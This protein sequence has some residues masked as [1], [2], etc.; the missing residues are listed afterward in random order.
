MNAKI[1]IKKLSHIILV[2]LLIC[3]T[4]SFAQNKE[5]QDSVTLNIAPLKTT[6]NEWQFEVKIQ[7]KLEKSIYLAT[8]PT[9]VYGTKGHY[10]QFEDNADSLLKISSR[11]FPMPSVYYYSNSTRVILKEIKPAEIFSEIILLKFPLKE[12]DPPFNHFSDDQWTKIINKT[13]TDED[14]KSSG[15]KRHPFGKRIIPEEIKTVV[16]SYGYFFEEPGI[17]DL[18]RRKY[19]FGAVNGSDRP[20]IGDFKEKSLFEIQNLITSD[21]IKINLSSN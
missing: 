10:L 8:E 6:K 16:V 2:I 4:Q 13:D 19:L 9:Q 12:T 17:I 7:N 14:F 5:V 1:E 18:I 21:P 3:I 11:V 15:K 20:F